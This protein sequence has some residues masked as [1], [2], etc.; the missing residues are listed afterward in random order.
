MTQAVLQTLQGTSLAKQDSLL[1]VEKG[2]VQGLGDME[3]SDLLTQLTQTISRE[4]DKQNKD[5]YDVMMSRDVTQ[6]TW[7]IGRETKRIKIGACMT[8]QTMPDV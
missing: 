6:L 5:R 4:R 3:S 1:G 8:S 2:L 7:R